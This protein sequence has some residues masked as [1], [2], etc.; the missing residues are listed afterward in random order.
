MKTSIQINAS[1]DKVWD[2]ISDI[3]NDSAYWK[4]IT[5]IRNISRENNIVKREVTLAKTNRCL[6]TIT[7]YPKE[8]IHTDWTRG[9]IT[10]TKDITL[11]LKDG[12]TNLEVVMDYKVSGMAGFLSGKI[13]KDMEQEAN[14]AI[15]LIKDKADGTIDRGLQMEERKHWADQFENK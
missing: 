7:F 11:I 9:I 3:D 15:S 14:M 8:K 12:M 5:S 10:G 6:Q 4:G 13:K 1:I 2:V